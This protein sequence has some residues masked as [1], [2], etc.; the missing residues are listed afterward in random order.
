MWMLALGFAR[1]H[2]D[3]AAIALIGVCLAGAAVT[4]HVQRNHARA[5]LA[6]LQAQNAADA[7]VRQALVREAEARV[8]AA[9]RQAREAARSA[10]ERYEQLQNQYS[11]RARD[12]GARLGMCIAAAAGARPV[13]A[14][15][16]TAGG[17]DDP[18]PVAGGG[19]APPEVAAA[20]EYAGA[21]ADDAARLT[22]LQQWVRDRP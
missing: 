20:V 9:E 5:Q 10:E 18:G 16:G 22:A 14:A 13:P 21:C 11:G 6:T 8:K 15:G 1:K 3:L 17:A 7:A 19:G 2:W 4:F 12:L